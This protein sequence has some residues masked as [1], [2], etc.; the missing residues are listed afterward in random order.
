MTKTKYD[1]IVHSLQKFKGRPSRGSQATNNDYRWNSS[2]IVLDG[3]AGN[4]VLIRIKDYTSGMDLTDVVQVAYKE[5]FFD[6]IHG[7]HVKGSGHAGVRTTHIAVQKK[8][9][10]V[11]RQLCQVFCELCVCMTQRKMS[12]RPQDIKPLISFTF[13][14]RGQVDLM[15]FQ[16]MKSGPH[17]WVMVYQDHHSKVCILRALISKEAKPVAFELYMIF[18]F[19]GAPMILQSD[20]GKEFTA[21]VI[22]ELKSLWPQLFIVHGRARHPQSQ[23]S[24][25]RANQDIKKLILNWMTENASKLWHIGIHIVQF[26]KNARFHSGIQNVPYVLLFGQ[27]PKMALSNLPF[28]P[29]L[30]AKLNTEE[31]LE[32]LISSVNS[33]TLLPEVNPSPAS[34]AITAPFQSTSSLSHDCLQEDNA[35]HA[36][37]ASSYQSSS[38]SSFVSP[39]EQNAIRIATPPNPPFTSPVCSPLDYVTTSTSQPTPVIFDVG[40][41]STPMEPIVAVFNNHGDTPDR[42]LKR[43]RAAEA[44]MKQGEKMKRFSTSTSPGETASPLSVGSVVLLKPDRVDRGQVDPL[45]F[46]AIVVEITEHGLFRLYAPGGVLQSCYG[47]HDLYHEQNKTPASYGAHLINYSGWKTAETITEKSAVTNYS[48]A[49]GQGFVKCS[50]KGNCQ[51][52]KCQ[53]KK[54]G[55]LCNSRCHRSNLEACTNK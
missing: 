51:T 11:T 32:K 28:D 54:R 19:I 24:V 21:K 45:R 38:S 48:P 42:G 46:P 31:E 40:S 34:H 29:L 20:N 35:S 36:V 52:G 14:Q 41:P 26:Q 1:Q 53:C 18:C 9:C 39:T 47:R 49:G 44:L 30:L 37:I 8:Y 4:P 23:G 12:V 33:I 55:V 2:Y 17:S 7:L 25:E 43:Q 50:C 15:D 6:I 16:S 5:Q 13:N 22:L 3:L 10:N 27:T